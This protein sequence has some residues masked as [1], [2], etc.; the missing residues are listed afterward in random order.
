M[1]P[2]FC[3][4]LLI[5][6]FF[7]FSACQTT[8]PKI[9]D[10]KAQFSGKTDDATLSPVSPSS[11]G[12]GSQGATPLNAPAKDQ[13]KK[14]DLDSLVLSN[15]EIGSP[16]SL[17]KAVDL[18]NADP[19]GLTDRNR[20]ALTIAGELMKL[21]YPLEIISWPMPSIPETD[22]Y[23]A[24][25]KSA[26][27]GVYDYSAGNK[28]FLSRVLPSLVLIST[29]TAEDYYPDAEKSLKQAANIN[30]NSVLPPL[31][32]AFL[33]QKQNNISL[34]DTQFEK[35]W[36]LD[37]SC[38]LA[39]KGYSLALNRKGQHEKS[40]TIARSLLTVYPN[41]SEMLKLCAQSAFL[42]KNWDTADTYIVAVLRTEPDNLDFLL[43]RSRI[44]IEKKEYLKAN[45]LLD[46]YSSKNK[47]NKDYL[48]LRARLAREWNKNYTLAIASLQEAHIL[49]SNDVD[50][51]LASAELSYQSGLQINGF[52]GRDFINTVLQKEATNYT[53]LF[54]LSSDYINTKEWSLALSNT[55]KLDSLY[56]SETTKELLVRALLGSGQ[57]QKAVTEALALYTT[58][59][60][61]DDLT[62]LYL[63][64]LVA[65]GNTAQ[66]R[67][68]IASRLSSASAQLKSILYF[69]ESKI[70]PDGESALSSLRSSLLSDPR[71]IQALFAMYQWYFDRNDYRKAQYYL[72]Q[73]IALDSKN[74]TY[75]K[76]LINLDELLAR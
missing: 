68:L 12:G 33:Y 66:I 13:L 4:S 49:Y 9:I 47:T 64:A 42:G 75:G 52:T 72:K 51:L 32:L 58:N 71:N 61:N 20:I 57:A 15:I 70:Q 24:S 59:P 29:S 34:S 6:V 14:N 50:V 11:I 28:D 76:L 27:M 54:L 56:P 43:M 41:S 2:K 53:A 35:A 69:Y 25:V 23:M 39:G 73:V 10:S 16:A 65:S 37:S 5:F 74:S 7:V 55:Q 19:R 8:A 46:A 36:N 44:L 1:N 63:Q 26:R 40:L 30:P 45:S 60:A 31:L 17:K 21:L 3:V 48:L 62:A 38:Y 22:V 67:T 18:I